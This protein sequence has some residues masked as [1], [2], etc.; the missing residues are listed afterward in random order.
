MKL[1][2]VEI[3]IMIIVV[4]ACVAIAMVAASAFGIAIPAWVVTMFWIVVVACAAI[5]AIKFISGMG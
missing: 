5:Y 4:L 3:L 1:K 2:F